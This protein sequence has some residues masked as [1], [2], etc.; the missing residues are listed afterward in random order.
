MKMSSHADFKRG[1]GANIEM[2]RGW[3]RGKLHATFAW[4][5]YNE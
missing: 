3:G 2:G 1:G 4:N 5:Y